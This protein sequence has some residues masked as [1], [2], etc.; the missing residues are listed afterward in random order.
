M[1]RCMDALRITLGPLAT[2]CLVAS[3]TPGPNNLL[4]MRSGAAF[5]VRRSTSHVLGIHA[6]FI[7]L[8]LACHL[9]IGALLLALPGVFTVLHWACFAYLLWLAVVIFREGRG[10][11][12]AQAAAAPVALAGRPMRWYES[13]LFQLVNPKA[14][15]MAV[16]M[17][18]AFYG[19]SA[20]RMV[21]IVV[22]AV[23]WL[24][25]GTP[26]MLAWTA[27]GASIDRLLSRPRER[28]AYAWA[29]SLTV[30]ATA[31]WMLQ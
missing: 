2:F 30:G 10:A 24:A 29:M 19:A 20:P 1:L 26:S 31:L 6:G 16:T 22:A 18:S 12:T 3:I 25:I 4:L 11:A 15:M 28:L 9:G 13:A 17:A 27:W 8:L 5:G 14:W 23:A 21:D 7:V